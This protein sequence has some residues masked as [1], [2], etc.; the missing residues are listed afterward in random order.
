MTSYGRIKKRDLIKEMRH[1]TKERKRKK[2]RKDRE[3][4]YGIRI[5][6]FKMVDTIINLY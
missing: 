3:K 5:Y 4:R 6:T 1:K 2:L